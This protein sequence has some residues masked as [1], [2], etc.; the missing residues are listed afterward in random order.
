MSA[1]CHDQYAVDDIFQFAHITR[2]VIIHQH[3]LDPRIECDLGCGAAHAPCI[4]PEQE[5]DQRREV[6][7]ALPQRRD[8]DVKDA[9]PGEESLAKLSHGKNISKATGWVGE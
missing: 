7:T 3:F 5:F 6:L 4:A 9:E 8:V 2:P 1:V